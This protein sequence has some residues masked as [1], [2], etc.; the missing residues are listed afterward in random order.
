M[1]DNTGIEAYVKSDD[2][3]SV[4]KVLSA[5]LGEF[6][7]D[8]EIDSGQCLYLS[9]DVKLLVNENIQD[10]YLSVWLRG[11]NHW[12]TDVQLARFLSRNLKLPVRCDPGADYP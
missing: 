6:A 12:K 10:G 2:A 7:L 3:K 4:L 5:E 8:C 1:N 9:G 11:T